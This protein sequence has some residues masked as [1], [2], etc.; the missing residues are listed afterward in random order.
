MAR[1]HDDLL[2]TLNDEQKDIF[3]KFDDCWSEYTSY[4]EAAIFEYAFRLGAKLTMEIH[5]DEE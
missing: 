4:A 5:K 3:E 2:K 1:H